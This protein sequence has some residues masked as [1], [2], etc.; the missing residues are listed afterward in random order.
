MLKNVTFRRSGH[1]HDVSYIDNE[2]M[3]TIKCLLMA[4]RF[5]KEVRSHIEVKHSHTLLGAYN[6]VAPDRRPSGRELSSFHLKSNE[7][8]DT[9]ISTEH[10]L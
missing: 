4:L 9:L 1:S 6:I 10:A 2:W 8:I 7:C 3:E 5:G